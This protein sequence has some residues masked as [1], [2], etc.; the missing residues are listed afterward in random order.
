[1]PPVPGGIGVCGSAGAGPFAGACAAG[2]FVCCGAGC[3][4]PGAGACPKAA[5]ENNSRPAMTTT[6]T[7]EGKTDFIAAPVGIFKTFSS[8]CYENANGLWNAAATTAHIDRPITQHHRALA[9]RRRRE[10][11]IHSGE[12][13]DRREFRGIRAL[14]GEN[15]QRVARFQLCERERGHGLHHLLNVGATTAA[16]TASFA[17][18]STG[19][20]AASTRRTV[21][22]ASRGAA[23]T[24]TPT[25]ARAAAPC[26]AIGHRRVARGHHLGGLS[27]HLLEF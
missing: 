13:G 10:N 11:R 5:S 12:H 27:R 24:I 17:G 7:R 2:F 16:T 25:T 8:A 26:R 14:R 20:S 3:C 15:H 23:G 21:S 19:R 6:T 4:A 22:T 9:G 18:R 1:M